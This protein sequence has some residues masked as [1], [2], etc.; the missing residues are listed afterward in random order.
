MTGRL[1]LQAAL[2]Q[3]CPRVYYQPP[4]N[5]KLS[6]P[7]IVYNLSSMWLRHADSRTFITKDRYQVTLIAKDPDTAMRKEITESLSGCS[8][9]RS[10]V[11]ENLHHFVY[12]VY[13]KN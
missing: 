10:F 7:C 3:I 1:G 6:Y 12:E 2:E 4:E 9:D 11:S 8:F 5:L 13:W